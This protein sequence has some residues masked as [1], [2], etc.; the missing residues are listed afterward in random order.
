MMTFA[1][2]ESRKSFHGRKSRDSGISRAK[3]GRILLHFL[4]IKYLKENATK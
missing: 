3:N 1:F 4:L 2:M